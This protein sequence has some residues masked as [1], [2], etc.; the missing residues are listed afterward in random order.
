MMCFVKKFFIPLGQLASGSCDKKVYIYNPA[1][2]GFSD[3]VRDTRPYE[4]HRASVEDIQW[5]P[6]N[7]NMFASCKFIYSI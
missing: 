4:Y 2:S 6:E 7:E 1:N 5:S 3:I